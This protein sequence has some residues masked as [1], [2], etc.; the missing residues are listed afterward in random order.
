[1]KTEF[2]PQQSITLIQEMLNATK[3][4]LKSSA[5]YYL[6]WGWLVF[7]SAITHYI[8]FYTLNQKIAPIIWPITMTLGGVITGIMSRKD[9]KENFPLT[10]AYQVMKNAL[11]AL[12]AAISFSILIGI[13]KGWEIAYPIFMMVY[14]FICVVNGSILKFNPL[15]IGGYISFVLSGA[16]LFVGFQYQLLLLALAI[17]VSYIIPAYLLKKA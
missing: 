14:G 10:Y 15:K 11:F 12:L 4:D 2:T 6:L 16:S 9:S 3:I 13:T 17:L 5:K 1:M 8:L 7:G